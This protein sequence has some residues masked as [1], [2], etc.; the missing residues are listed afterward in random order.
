MSIRLLGAVAALVFAGACGSDADDGGDAAAAPAETT[1]EAGPSDDD[2]DDGSDFD[3]DAGSVREQT[4]AG[5]VGIGYTE[6]EATCVFEAIDFSDPSSFNE[7]ERYQEILA[8]C[9]ISP[10]RILELLGAGG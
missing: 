7:V 8:G 5:L 3:A 10:E 1:E 6:E 4:I 9:G 2:L